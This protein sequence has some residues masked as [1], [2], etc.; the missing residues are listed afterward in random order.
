MAKYEITDNK[1]GKTVV[2]EGSRPPTTTDAEAIFQ[3]AGLRQT[4][5]PEPEK[6]LAS[7]VTDFLFGR[8]KDYIGKEGEAL[9]NRSLGENLSNDALSAINPL[10]GLSTKIENGKLN[11]DKQG[12]GAAGEVAS[13]MIPAN[14]L[15]KG[16]GSLSKIAGGAVQGAEIG[17]VSGVTDPEANNIKERIQKGVT[18]GV[19]GGVTGGVMQGAV[20]GISKAATKLKD[21]GL[22]IYASTFKENKQALQIIKRLGGPEN[23]A[24]ELI[25]NKIPKTKGG[26]RAELDKLNGKYETEVTQKLKDVSS[27]TKLDFNSVLDD[28]LKDAQ[29]RFDLP[30]P[31]DKRNLKSA[32]DYIES[33]R[34][35][36][37]NDPHLAN[38]LRKRLDKTYSGISMNEII[39][40]EKWA[41]DTLANKLRH[42]VQEVAPVTQPFFKKYSLLK[43]AESLFYKEPKVGFNELL[44]GITSTSLSQNPLIGA[45]LAR[46]VKSPGAT[47]TVG[48]VM[49]KVPQV[50]NNVPNLLRTSS[51]NSALEALTRQRQ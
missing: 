24:E 51:I 15:L 42:K 5:Q 37:A 14:K 35:F 20:E 17:A 18:S 47:R 26:V 40:G 3:K 39:S 11:F 44:G 7:K 34:N 46:V 36:N 2:V 13:Y 8:T 50:S 1:T 19:V 28:A 43:D 27:N 41:N 22:G 29:E 48:S 21:A 32:V 33:L 25:R 12:L 38:E 4:V 16:A 49:N 45:L 9:K 6:G 10:L 23:A 30:T 31:S